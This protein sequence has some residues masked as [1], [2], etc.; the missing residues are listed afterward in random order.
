M[1]AREQRWLIGSSL[2]LLLALVAAGAIF[3]VRHVRPVGYEPRIEIP[4][5]G[6]VVRFLGPDW[7]H[8][9]KPGTPVEL[10]G[11][12]WP[13]NTLPC[14]GYGIRIHKWNGFFIILY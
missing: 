12:S 5:R 14:E 13:F 6:V 11:F 10:C 3:C 9:Y 1:T 8:I 4:S 2:A 7:A